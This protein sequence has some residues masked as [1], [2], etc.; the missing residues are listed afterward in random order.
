MFIMRFFKKFISFF[1]WKREIFTVEVP[2]TC[3]DARQKHK[4]LADIFE[5]LEQEIK[6]H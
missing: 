3:E 1:Q 2:T 5:I 4:L 6:I